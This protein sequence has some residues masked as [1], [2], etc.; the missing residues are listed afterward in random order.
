GVITALAFAGAAVAQPFPVKPVRMVI[1]IG[2]G[3]SMD[4]VG[5]VL[6]QKLNE[7]WSQPVIVDNRAGA[8][9]TIGIDV[10]A[11][12]A[13]D[14]YTIL[15]GSS[16]VAIGS[17]YYRKL[18]Y[19]TVRDLEPI[20]QISSR[21]NVLVVALSSPYQ[22]VKDVIAAARAKP[23]QM[24]Y[25]SG[26]GSGSS[27][28]LAGEFFKLLAGVDILHVP[29]KSG[30]GA[31]T[32]LMNGQ[33]SIYLGGIP[34]NLPMIKAGKV[35]ALGTSGLKR[36]AQLPN[37][38]TIAEAGLPG[39]EV[40]VWYGLFA[41]RATPP[42]IVDRIAADVTTIVRTA[43]MRERFV[44]LGVDPEGGTPAAFRA[45]FRNDIERWRKVVKAAGVQGD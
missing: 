6:A 34:I 29:Y 16:S 31:L 44:A 39:F 14:G 38:P 28:H 30:P 2:P 1:H 41:P 7:A 4:I 23:G 24:S 9:G 13:P 10:V 37:V 11:K 33:L 21:H 27:D 5:R 18:P 20:V 17:S 42:G 19:D 25:G 43:E 15:F 22:S 3:S 8:G 12:A 32:D 40:N 45:Y 35:R 26:G 36:S